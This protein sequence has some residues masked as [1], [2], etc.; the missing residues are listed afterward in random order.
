LSESVK[1]D[2]LLVRELLAQ[3]VGVAAVLSKLAA[4]I[5]A[6][7]GLDDM[8]PAGGAAAEKPFPVLERGG[9]HRPDAARGQSRGNLNKRLAWR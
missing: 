3:D 2:A 1:T 5:R 4:C 6:A 7:A 8:N 9:R